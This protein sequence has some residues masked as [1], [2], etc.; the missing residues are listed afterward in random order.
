MNASPNSLGPGCGPAA[1]L[2]PEMVDVAF[3]LAGG[4]LARGFEWALFREIA[5][6]LPWIAKTPR[7]GI[8]PLRGPRTADG[9]LMITQRSRIVI[10]L[11]RDRV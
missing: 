8:L 5:R 2:L 1:A 10:R 9:V 7:A 11:P 3:G 4:S 6:I